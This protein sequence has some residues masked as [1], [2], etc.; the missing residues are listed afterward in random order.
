VATLSLVLGVVA[1]ALAETVA[2]ELLLAIFMASILV[3]WAV[4]LMDHAGWLPG[5]GHPAGL[6][7][8]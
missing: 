5:G 4:E 2:A 3:V 8:A 7:H 1:L 6:T